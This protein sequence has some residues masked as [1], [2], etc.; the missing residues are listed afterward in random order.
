MVL[1]AI[2]IV[3]FVLSGFAGVVCLM[4]IIAAVSGSER[5]RSV[6]AISI[7]GLTAIVLLALGGYLLL[8]LSGPWIP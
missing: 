8:R 2:A 4:C 5:R 3:C 1:F 6:T 7:S